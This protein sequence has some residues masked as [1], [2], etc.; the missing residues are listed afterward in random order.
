VPRQEY[1]DVC[2]PRRRAGGLDESAARRDV[3]NADVDPP[4][5][6]A[7]PSLNKHGAP[8]LT[9]FHSAW[10]LIDLGLPPTL[11]PSRAINHWLRSGYRGA[12]IFTASTAGA[13]GQV[14]SFPD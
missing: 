10:I 11:Q 2:P 4:G 6:S 1:F 12:M 5:T 13:S 3:P 14:R 9:R 7:H 8:W